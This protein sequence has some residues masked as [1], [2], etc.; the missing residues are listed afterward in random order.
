MREL[1]LVLPDDVW[2]TNLTGHGQPRRCSTGGE[3]QRCAAG[4]DPGPRWSWS[5]APA[6]RRPS[7]ASSQAL[8]GHRR[9]HPGR[10][11][12]SSA[13]RHPEASAGRRLPPGATATA[14]RTR[15]FVAQF[16]IVGRLRRRARPGRL[17]GPRRP[18]P[19]R[20]PRPEASRPASADEAPARDD[21]HAGLMG[22]ANRM[23]VA[24]LVVAA[25]A[26]GFWVL[27]LGP[28]REKAD[29]TA[30]PGRTGCKDPGQAQSAGGRGGS[31]ATRVPRRLPAA[32]RARQGGAAE[33]RNLLPAGRAEPI[34]GR[35]KVT[36][37]GIAIQRGRDLGDAPP[38]G[39]GPR[40]A[41]PAPKHSAVRRN[42]GGQLGAPPRTATVPPTEAA[43]SLLPLGAD[44]RPGRARRDA[45]QAQ[46]HR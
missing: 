12:Q 11:C 19:P 36:F 25:L 35:S 43:A 5:A 14:A 46:L 40:P 23:I 10:G 34:A 1:A 27:L 15:D 41:T 17:A 13:A 6:A 32:G 33:R 37:D 28:K 24:I 26:V 21:L 31:S 18:P 39:T 22:S 38:T 16:Q 45:V 4:F 42:G 7:P 2:L 20:P 9:R 30:R 3:R 29:E 8:Q 44:D